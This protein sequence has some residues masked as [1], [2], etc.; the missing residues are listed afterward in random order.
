MVVRWGFLGAGWIASRALAPAMHAA[1]GAVLQA[2]AARSAERA[3]GLR[4]A[5]RVH[6]SY[7]ALLAD[8]E[9]DAVYI[10]LTNEV[11]ASWSIAAMRAGKH[12]L[13]EK[14]LAM[15]A[16]EVDAMVAVS[17]E[18]GRLLVEASWYRWHP[19]VRRTQELLAAGHIGAVRHVSAG[20]TFA[21]R[22]DGNYRL[23]PAR[24]GGALYDVGCYAVSAAMWAFGWAPVREVAARQE[25]GPSGVDLVTEAVVT[26][27]AGDA[28][29]RAGISEPPRQW[30]VISGE[31][32]EL[33]LRDGSYTSWR[34]DETLLLVSDGVTTE[35][36]R[37]PPVDAYR[38]MVEET[39]RAVAGADGWVVPLPESRATAAVLDA[40]FASA[41]AGGVAVRPT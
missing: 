6:A 12:V 24:G 23:D 34:D 3:G 40:A 29:L 18:T 22:L 2:V 11:H 7:D 15:N 26:F 16:D 21:G 32:G 27:D 20:F 36:E 39:S 41:R 33:E 31:R 38:L 25:I 28:Q 8:D 17:Q 19:R 9:V 35:P 14:P 37:F 1:D 5:G 30:L 13:C 4:P 10:S